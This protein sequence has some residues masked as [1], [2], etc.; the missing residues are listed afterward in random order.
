MFERTLADH[1][2][3]RRNRVFTTILKFF[4]LLETLTT[5]LDKFSGSPRPQPHPA[6][7]D[8]LVIMGSLLL[9]ST[10][11]TACGAISMVT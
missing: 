6:E 7:L 4:F 2:S 8:L 9:R 10:R 11:S 1:L 5:N 3:F